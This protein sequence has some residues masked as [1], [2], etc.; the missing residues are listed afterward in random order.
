MALWM[1]DDLKLRHME[2]EDDMEKSKS[3]NPLVR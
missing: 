1:K 3:G 2:E